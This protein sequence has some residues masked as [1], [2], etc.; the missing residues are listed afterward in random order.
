MWLLTR[1]RSGNMIRLYQ[2]VRFVLAALIIRSSV[3]RLRAFFGESG[4]A[5]Q[6]QNI[7]YGYLDDANAALLWFYEFQLRG[8]RLWACLN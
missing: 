5:R 2:V 7:G 4:V 3:K 8:L 1:I 6:G